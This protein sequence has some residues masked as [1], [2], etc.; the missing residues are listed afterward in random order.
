MTLLR[1][2]ASSVPLVILILIASNVLARAQQ[3]EIRTGFWRGNK[4]TYQWISGPNGTGKAVY[5]GDILLDNVQQSVQQSP[6]G[7]GTNGFGIGYSQYL[8]PK[9]G[10]VAQ[11]PY[12]I[13]PTSGDL[14]NL[15]TAITQFNSTFGGVIQLVAHGSETNY[16]DFNFNSGDTS[17]VCDAFEG[18][19]GGPQVVGGS[20]S[21]TVATILHEMGHTVGVWHEQT[22]LDRDTYVSVNYNAVIKGSRGNFDPISDNQQTLSPYDYASV[23]EYPAFS[24]SRNGEP[25]IETIPA[26]I[27]LS[28]PN[29]YTAADVDGIK[30]L[31]GTIP[32]QVTVTSNPPGLQ[33]IVDGSTVTTPQTFAWALNST[34]TLNVAS[35]AQTLGGINYAYGRWNDATAQSHTITVTPGNNM[36]TQ[37]AT[38]P[39]ITV[40]SANFIQLVPYVNAISPAGAGTVTPSPAPLAYSGLTGQ[41][42]T[43]RQLVTLTAAPS[44]GQNFY[45]Y[46]GSP[47]NS[48]LPGGT[49]ANPKTFYVPDASSSNINIITYFTSSPVYTVT[50]N[51]VFF[52]SL[53]LR[54]QYFFLF[55]TE[56][57]T[58]LRPRLD[59]IKLAPGEYRFAG[60]ALEFQLALR[61]F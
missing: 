60:R 27:P 55:A 10:G 5:Q 17:G 1:R 26:G 29:G 59:A 28:N 25:C 43:I 18:V 9:V 13:D 6:N 41:Y 33:V 39:A 58:A 42:Y 53:H 51:P 37:P 14:T 8:W 35:A 22:R 21:C 3:T 38:A 49:G 56:F 31:Y 15:N 24:F 11:V 36:V 16:V 7:A 4:V 54:R 52:E 30:R 32:T 19:V 50:T 48:N 23:M 2:L 57:C 44:A 12:T 34:H 47:G 20:G 45:N 46:L 40:Y 61:V